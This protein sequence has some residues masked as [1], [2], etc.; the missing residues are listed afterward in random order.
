MSSLPQPD[1]KRI[2][3]LLTLASEE[4]RP[5]ALRPE[6]IIILEDA[7]M[8]VDAFTAQFWRDPAVEPPALTLA[9][10]VVLLAQANAAESTIQ[11]RTS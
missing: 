11:E 7:G 4:G 10:L 9:S 2:A 1:D 6:T 3:E 5:L 8:V